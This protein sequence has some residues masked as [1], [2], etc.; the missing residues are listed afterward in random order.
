MIGRDEAFLILA[1]YDP[2][3]YNYFVKN[4]AYFG[5]GALAYAAKLKKGARNGGIK[6]VDGE[7]T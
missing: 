1:K 3:T 4:A 6:D 5:S 2:E 7:R